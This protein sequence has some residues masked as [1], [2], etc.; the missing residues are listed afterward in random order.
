MCGAFEKWQGGQC[1]CH[2]VSRGESVELR[3][4]WQARVVLWR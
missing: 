2:R 4:V 1:D 3:S